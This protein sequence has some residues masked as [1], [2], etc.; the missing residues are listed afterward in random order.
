MK[1]HLDKNVERFAS[2]VD[3]ALEERVEH[4]DA[5]DD[6]T[7]DILALAHMMKAL[8]GTTPEPDATFVDRLDDT[9]RRTATAFNSG[10]G[11][12]KQLRQFINVGVAFA[13]SFAL[14]LAAF[15][16]WKAVDVRR[17]PAPGI[18][19]EKAKAF[20]DFQNKLRS[21]QS[22]TSESRTLESAEILLFPGIEYQYEWDGGAFPSFPAHLPV[23]KKDPTAID[24]TT[25]VRV[26]RLFDLDDRPVV[27]HIESA[28]GGS[29][30]YRFGASYE[31]AGYWLEVTDVDDRFLY[32]R[33]V[34]DQKATQEIGASMNEQD[35]VRIATSFL[36]SKGLLPSGTVPRTEQYVSPSASV[37][38]RVEPSGNINRSPSD[39]SNIKADGVRVY[40]ERSFD[41]YPHV[42]DGGFVDSWDTWVAVLPGG[43]IDA[44]SGI[45]P[46]PLVRSDYPLIPVEMAFEDLRSGK[47]PGVSILGAPYTTRSSPNDAAERDIQSSPGSE[48]DSGVSPSNPGLSEPAPVA[49]EPIPDPAA[50][51]EK[52][53]EV[54]R[55][56]AVEIGYRRLVDWET[57][58]TYFE[59]VYV[60]RGRFSSSG[61]AYSVVVPATKAGSR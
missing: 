23:Y 26:A 50:P 38:V 36:E 10:S 31:E 18:T 55:L 32:G 34:S 24:R 3:E 28:V 45:L 41:G 58:V 21:G 27:E 25:A 9:L 22:L 37:S 43:V 1:D 2:R 59:P 4:L 46:S 42:N 15:L 13:S 11:M 49:P 35:A 14:L 47:Y 54:I 7:R 56:N 8:S 52:I 19:S 30:F 12:R 53:I 16:I 6:E 51:P 40:F 39:S 57:A 48:M 5:V 20:G 33:N 29:S 44:A 17:W 60:F 61:E